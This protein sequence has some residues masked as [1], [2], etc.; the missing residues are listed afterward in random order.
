MVAR[1]EGARQEREALKSQCPI[2]PLSTHLGGM[3]EFL[4]RTEV[5]RNSEKTKARFTFEIAFCVCK[6][7]TL[8]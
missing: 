4:R 3:N 7:S 8:Y 5:P 6:V 2:Y 1:E